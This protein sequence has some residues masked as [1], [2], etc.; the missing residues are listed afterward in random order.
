MEKHLV[1]AAPK[2]PAT[3]NQPGWDRDEAGQTEIPARPQIERVVAAV[4]RYRWL[5]LG[6]LGMAI[7]GG[8]IGIR[9]LTPQYQVNATIWI[10]S[11]T[12]NDRNSVGPIR[13]NELLSSS[14][15]VELLRTNRV[16]DAVVRKLALYVIPVEPSDQHIFQNFS[17]ADRFAPGQYELVVDPKAKRW[18]LKMQSSGAVEEGGM[19]DSVGR[20]LG[21][22]WKVPSRLFN[23]PKELDVAFT[24]ETPREASK[25]LLDD[26]G[27]KLAPQSNFLRLT[28][29]NPNRDIAERTLNTWTAEYV[30]VAGDLKKRNMV[31][32]SRIL[33]GQLDFAKKSLE[34]AERALEGFRVHTITLPA[35]GGP[36]A[37]GV[38]ATR[39]PAMSSY[40]NQKQQY[41][42]LKNDR[43]SLEK[44][45]ATAASG[46]APYEGLLLIPSVTEN[47]GGEA[48][49][50]AFKRQYSLQAELSAKRA[51]FTD[52]YLKDLISQLNTLQQVTIP[53]LANQV[54]SS[55]RE[56]EIDFERRIGSASK[57]MRAIPARTIEEMRLRRNVSIADGLYT[58]LKTRYAEA[59][60]AEAGATPDVNVLDSAVAPLKPTK[61]TAPG[62]MALA[63][64]GGIAAAIG[65]AMLLDRMD[66]RFRYP[67]Q[68]TE[69]LGLSIVGVVPQLPKGGLDSRSPEQVLQ[70]VESFR[71]LRLHVVHAVRG[72]VT[73]AISSP[74]PGDGKSLVSA[75][76]AMSFAEAGYRTVL[77]DGDTR[78]GALHQMFAA[79]P[80]NGLTEYLFGEANL[81]QVLVPTGH[82]KLTLIACGRRHHRSPEFLTSPRLQAL[83]KELGETFD[84]AIFDTPPLAAGIDGYALSAAAGNLLMVVRIGQTERRLAAAKLSLADRL[85][86][87][88]VGTVLNSVELNGEFQYYGY[89]SG[90]GVEEPAELITATAEGDSATVQLR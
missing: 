78:R 20:K 83:V 87:N 30:S 39:D 21:F 8:L 2:N 65:L 88:I 49:R 73:I 3:A 84:V 15:W 56:R 52:E 23:G 4:R 71:S 35:E 31:E 12:P 5:A 13:S 25:R 66:K 18:T 72:P 81:E 17:I 34:D 36:V 69:G 37:A 50:D 55:L 33:E 46:S 89:A 70:L 90:Y 74:A 6:V 80:P 61:N 43:E 62:I 85:P 28:Y 63:V 1:P 14:A 57:E 44:A 76:L 64:L 10:E 54:L 68:A 16:V 40:F 26:L 41:D 59:K 19:T 77:V 86:I 79:K 42:D 22:R 11:E 48:L 60:L 47:A 58:T 45:I 9:F 29:E 7:I 75:N 53:G 32:F 24:V 82:D 67:E 27:T 51:T 38:E